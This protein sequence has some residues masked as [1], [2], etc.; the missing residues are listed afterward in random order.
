MLN[1]LWA[2]GEESSARVWLMFRREE[3]LRGW[4]KAE[5]VNVKVISELVFHLKHS[6][7]YL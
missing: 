2:G 4:S 1:G 6:E 7:S 5:R 3:R